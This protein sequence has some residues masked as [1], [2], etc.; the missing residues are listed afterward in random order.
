MKH[1]KNHFN[2]LAILNELEG[3]RLRLETNQIQTGTPDWI[4][5]MCEAI[6]ADYTQWE[7]RA[8]WLSAISIAKMAGKEI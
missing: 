2:C 7:T 6:V 3:F 8:D 5:R 1:T 4:V